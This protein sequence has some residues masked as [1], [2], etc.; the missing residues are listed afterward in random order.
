[1]IKKF[2]DFIN[3]DLSMAK[4]DYIKAHSNM[5]MEEIKS[6]LVTKISERE[7]KKDIIGEI[8]SGEKETQPTIITNLNALGEDTFDELKNI[9]RTRCAFV[10]D[11]EDFERFEQDLE[12]RNDEYFIIGIKELKGSESYRMLKKAMQ[13]FIEYGGGDSARE[14]NSSVIIMFGDNFNYVYD[15]IANII[16]NRLPYRILDIE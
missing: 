9:F 5:R 7:F 6:R 11:L 15:E 13:I 16:K 10:T 14:T 3:E 12:F 4:R 1:M 2:E 8:L